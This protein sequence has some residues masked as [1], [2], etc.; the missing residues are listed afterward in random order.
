MKTN[1]SM[2][3]EISRSACASTCA[4]F[5]GRMTATSAILNYSAQ[6]WRLPFRRSPMCYGSEFIATTVQEWLSKVGVKALYIA[7][8]SPWENGY[9][10]S[11][12]GSLRNEVSGA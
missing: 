7:P 12:N 8:G 2:M 9:S 1:R 6:A 5:K 4:P 10:K 3:T 11:F